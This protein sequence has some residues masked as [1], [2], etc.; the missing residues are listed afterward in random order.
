[1]D[2]DNFENAP[3]VDPEIFYIDKKDAFS[4]KSGY[5]DEFQNFRIFISHNLSLY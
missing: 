2:G 3:R 5:V 1:M 4:R